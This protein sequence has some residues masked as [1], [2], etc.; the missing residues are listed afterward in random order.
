MKK[1][2]ENEIIDLYKNFKLT[3]LEKYQNVDFS[4]K[5]IDENGY[6]YKISPYN[7]RLRK[8]LNMFTGAFN[9]KNPFKEDNIYH[10]M[11]LEGKDT[12]LLFLPIN[13]DTEECIFKCRV[14][15]NEFKQL[16]KMFKNSPNKCCQ[17]C[18]K[19][20][21]KSKKK[22]NS[23]VEEIFNKAGY[24]L[25]EDGNKGMHYAY[26]IEDKEGYRGRMLPYSA[27]KKKFKIEK[28]NFKNIYSIDN[29]NLY[30]NKNKINL[31]CIEETNFET[32]KKLKWKCSCGSTFYC[33]WDNVLKGKYRC[34][35]CSSIYS[36]NEEKVK[37]L[38]DFLG[39]RYI[40]QYNIGKYKQFNNLY[41]DFYLPELN[42]M[43]EIDGEQHYKPVRFG[44]I[45][46]NEANINF[47]K[48]KQRDRIKN[49]Y[50]KENNINLLRISYI[51]IKNKNYKNILS[52]KINDLR[53]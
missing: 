45:S 50:C 11:K 9:N 18:M 46:S 41:F 40:R 34:N 52:T 39:V 32:Y 10:F 6:K 16:F 13:I 42:L 38:L 28:Y 24:K 5:C 37:N 8:S 33:I 44:G 48:Q 7:L 27:K 51:D 35:D 43:L 26:Y 47:K 30:L 53:K 4:L 17:K 25:L 2:K 36:N 19:N 14:C 29:I 49:Q 1:Y 22:E 3:L 12:E 21:K 31:I 20:V 23:Y 15:G